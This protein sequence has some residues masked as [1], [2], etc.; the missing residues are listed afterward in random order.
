MNTKR[1]L[2]RKI[3]MLIVTSISV[4]GF[5][6]FCN[7]SFSPEE[8]NGFSRFVFIGVVTMIG[9]ITFE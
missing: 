1:I 3:W 5:L 7:W 9:I 8:W 4:F 6:S 2:R